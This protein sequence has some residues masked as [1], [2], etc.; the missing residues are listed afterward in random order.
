[1]RAHSPV[2]LK[3]TLKGAVNLIAYRIIVALLVTLLASVE[4]QPIALNP[5]LNPYRSTLQLSP[6]RRGG[7]SAISCRGVLGWRLSWAEG[8]GLGVRVGQAL[9]FR[10]WDLGFS[11]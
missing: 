7:N 9:G 1:M 11:V 8:L 2:A 4:G 3:A 10:V 5:Y 6:S